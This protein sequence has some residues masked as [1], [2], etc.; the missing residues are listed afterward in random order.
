MRESEAERRAPDA[1]CIVSVE[2]K[3][4][5]SKIAEFLLEGRIIYPIYQKSLSRPRLSGYQF[6]LPYF[7]TEKIGQNLAHGLVGLPFFRSRGDLN[8]QR[9]AK[10]SHDAIS[11][12][13]GNDFHV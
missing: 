10:H 9:I 6:N 3:K 5:L 8:L 12:C 1:I 11:G 2:R 13:A 7:H 4:Q